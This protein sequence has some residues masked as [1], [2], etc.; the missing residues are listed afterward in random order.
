MQK[1]FSIEKLGEW[2][3]N[4]VNNQDLPFVTQSGLINLKELEDF[5]TTIKK[6][7]ADS[8]RVYFL[9]FRVNETPTREVLVNGLVAEG[10]KW[11][12]ASS[13]FTQ[14]SIAIVPTKNFKRDENFIFSAE[15]IVI[16]NQ[17]TA[18]M[19]GVDEEGTGLNPPGTGKQSVAN[20]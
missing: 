11:W 6:L 8:V 1:D 19:P 3:S 12:Q 5:V 18:L 20:K 15:D 7:N 13:E 17:I 16:N 14:A 2:T 4:F 10:C 9:R